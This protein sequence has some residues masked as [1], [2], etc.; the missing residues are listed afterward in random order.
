MA[1]G[2]KRCGRRGY[3]GVGMTSGPGARRACPRTGNSAQPVMGIGELTGAAGSHRERG[4][5]HV[6]RATE[7]RT[8]ARLGVQAT[9]GRGGGGEL[10]RAGL[11]HR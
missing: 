9:V 5:R 3:R 7:R 10:S 4:A 8:L 2:V 11:G 6:G 1:G